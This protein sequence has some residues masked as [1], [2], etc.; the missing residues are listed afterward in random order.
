M[1]LVGIFEELLRE[2]TEPKTS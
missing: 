2:C 1:H